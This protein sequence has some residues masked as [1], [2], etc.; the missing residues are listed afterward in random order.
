[1]KKSVFLGALTLAG[2]A[3]TASS[4]TT[5]EDVKAR[6][7][8]NCGV[9]TGLVGFAAPDANGNWDFTA[10]S[11]FDSLSHF[12]GEGD[13]HAR[14]LWRSPCRGS[15]PRRA[16]RWLLGAPTHPAATE[17]LH[18]L[19]SAYPDYAFVTSEVKTVVANFIGNVGSADPRCSMGLTG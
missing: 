5:L 11:A 1:M 7:K 12:S 16:T 8:L 18:D 3:A 9:N 13:G 19:R 6:G 14:I 2:L 10:N 17:G 4:A 15:C